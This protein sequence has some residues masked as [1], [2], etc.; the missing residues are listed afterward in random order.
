M[1]IEKKKKIKN[2]SKIE[3]KFSRDLKVIVLKAGLFSKE[4][5]FAEHGSR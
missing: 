4:I 1:I 5:S 3:L 2:L